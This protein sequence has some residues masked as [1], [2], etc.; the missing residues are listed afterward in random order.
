MCCI[1][2]HYSCAKT[3][4]LLLVKIFINAGI[5]LNKRGT[6]LQHKFSYLASNRHLSYGLLIDLLLQKSKLCT[7]Q[8]RS[9]TLR[10]S[11]H[12][13]SI[14]YTNLAILNFSCAQKSWMLYF[15]LF[16][17]SKCL[18]QFVYHKLIALLSQ[19][20]LRHLRVVYW[21]TKYHVNFAS[22]VN[23]CRFGN[24]KQF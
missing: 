7:W 5:T 23:F 1:L 17:V 2:N 22:A 4:E 15:M 11:Y 18:R 3:K 21:T 8:T 9:W 19:S 10:K 14:A 16:I 12:A 13:A 6:C 20:L 24:F